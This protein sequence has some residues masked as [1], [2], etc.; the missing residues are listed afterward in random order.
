MSPGELVR[1]SRNV[2]LLWQRPVPEHAFNTINATEVDIRRGECVLVAG[3]VVEEHD[4][5]LWL[6]VVTGEGHF[7]WKRHDYF[8]EAS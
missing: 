2:A 4:C 3:A 6:F 8:A 5:C 7:G 1:V